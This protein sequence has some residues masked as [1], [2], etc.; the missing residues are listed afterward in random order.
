MHHETTSSATCFS[1]LTAFLCYSLI[2]TFK[3]SAVAGVNSRYDVKDNYQSAP[4]RSH[5][6]TDNPL[7]KQ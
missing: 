2:S 6:G 7:S 5:N 1:L 3:I 4:E